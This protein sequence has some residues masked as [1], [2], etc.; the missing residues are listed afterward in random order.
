LIYAET[1]VILARLLAEDRIPPD[2][3]WDESFVTSR[4]TEYEVFNRLHS[5]KLGD[6]HLETA[7]S[8]LNR[9]AFAELSSSVLARALEPFPIAVRTLDAL[10][11]ATLDFLRTR[12][13]HLVLATFDKRLIE[14]A[15]RMKFRLYHF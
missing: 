5:R 7:R 14:A 4:L 1:S 13:S 11:L 2:S 12:D 6:P 8:L 3:F 10:H 15:H 9:M